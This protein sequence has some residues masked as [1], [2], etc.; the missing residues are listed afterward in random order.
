MAKNI[1]H[2]EMEKALP[3]FLEFQKELPNLDHVV[4]DQE[5]ALTPRL[6]LAKA[7][8]SFTFGHFYAAVLP[9]ET[10][11]EIGLRE[12]MQEQLGKYVEQEKPKAVI[13]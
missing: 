4:I 5:F 13:S 11:V 10:A 7:M 6:F 2:E 9:A 1:F 3:R 12:F 8:Q